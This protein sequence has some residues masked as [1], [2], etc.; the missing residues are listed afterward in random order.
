L[1]TVAAT[2]SFSNFRSHWATF[3][4]ANHETNYSTIKSTFKVPFPATYLSANFTAIF[5]TISAAA[6]IPFPHTNFA[7]INTTIKTTFSTSNYAAHIASN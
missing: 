6:L 1:Y 4:T 3:F 5:P 2:I 7:A